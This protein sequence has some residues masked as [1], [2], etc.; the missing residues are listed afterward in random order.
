MK[1]QLKSL[2]VKVAAL[3]VGT[4]LALV[5]LLYVPL[6]YIELRSF[7]QL[8]E[9][10]AMRNVQRVRNEIDSTVEMLAAFAAD[11]ASWDDT[12]AYMESRDPTYIQSNFVESTFADNRLNLV[13][14]VAPDGKVVY[15]RAYDLEHETFVPLPESLRHFEPDDLLIRHPDEE[16]EVSGILT[17]PGA[18]MYFT[19][20]PI[21]TSNGEGPPRGAL[22][23]GRFIDAMEI[24]RLSQTTALSLTMQLVPSEAERAAAF[25]GAPVALRSD[26]VQVFP[27]NGETL[28]GCTVVNDVYGEPALLLRVTMDRS[29]YHYGRAIMLSIVLLLL[30]AGAIFGVVLIRILDKAVLSRLNALSADVV[31]VGALGREG[32][33]SRRVSV[34]GEDEIAHLGRGINAMLDDLARYQRELLI[35]KQRFEDLVAVAHATVEQPTLDLTLKN[36]LEVAR[37]LTDAER[38]SLFL[39]NEKG[40]VTYSV[41]ARRHVTPA[42]RQELV[43]VVMDSGLAGWVARHQQPALIHDVEDDPRWLPLPDAPYVVRSVL[44]LPIRSGSRE[45]GILT[46][47]HPEANHF[48]EDDLYL[49]QAAADQMALALR[50]AQIY[51]DQRRLAQRQ[52]ILYQ[53]L[54]TVSQHMEPESA[55]LV[56]VEMIA[57]LTGWPAVVILLHDESYDV[58]TVFAAAGRITVSPGWHMRTSQGEIGRAF[59]QRETRYVPDVKAVSDAVVLRYG[60]RSRIVVPLRHSQQTMGVLIIEHDY[61]RAFRPDDIVLAESLADT[62]ALAMANAR[63]FQAVAE[64]RSRLQALIASIRDG[65]LLF[66]LDGTV[67]VA[68]EAALAMLDLPGPPSAWVGR[69]VDALAWALRKQAPAAT[70]LFIREVKRLRLGFHP[71]AGGEIQVASRAIQWMNISVMRRE[72]PLGYLIVL[73]DVTEERLL[74]R[75]REDVVHMMVHDLRN[76]LTS[77]YGALKLLLGRKAYALTDEVR[78]ILEIADRNAQRMLDLINAILDLSRLESGQ[79]PLH[80]E[81]LVLA[82]VVDNVVQLQL[83]AAED[84]DI[85][86]ETHLPDDLPP[87]WA[88]AGLLERVLQNLVGNAIKFTP[89]GGTVRVEA[90][91]EAE[92]S[93]VVVRVR[94]TGPGISPEIR[95]RLFEKFTTGKHGQRGTGLGLAFCKM[96]LE[97][98]G[99]RIW[100]EHTGAQGT[101]F[102]FTLSPAP[103]APP[104]GV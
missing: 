59:R 95:E 2:R 8:E 86:L 12:Y 76:P 23:M 83:P 55:M 29:V 25:C 101:S 30:A 50:N 60:T 28:V 64:E 77:I 66:G 44:A 94:D 96:A 21:L 80:Q 19:S 16:S 15:G 45:V 35:Q 41:L 71:T 104:P 1:L 17:L 14:L 18:A 33:F 61:V 89:S 49:M 7:A 37:S 4:T 92:A 99:E 34:S 87:V 79:M 98:H 51:E 10:L 54:R 27:V 22:V 74:A 100:V 69:G 72:T 93:A 36:A 24:A 39:L 73:H 85:R 90:R 103:S 91:W 32:D 62:V 81:P 57:R 11:Y 84:K 47:T 88:D 9:Q 42:Q 102:A 48:T 52:T 63:L 70:R 82:D 46:L 75:M 58:L 53:V 6:S 13:L 68:N 3:I 67:L 65:I 38:G 31:R 97:A 78:Q 40:E 26:P 5:V 20:Q 43:S 56:A